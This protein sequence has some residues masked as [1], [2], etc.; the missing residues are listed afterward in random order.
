MIG[1]MPP[2]KIQ[3][4]HNQ[5]YNEAIII[6]LALYAIRYIQTILP[7]LPELTQHPAH[8]SPKTREKDRQSY[9]AAT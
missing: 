4:F 3:Y 1:R 5:P 9:Q 7:A 8:Q 2:S 6:I